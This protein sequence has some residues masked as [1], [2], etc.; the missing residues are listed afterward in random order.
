MNHIVHL[1]S[2]VIHMIV[3][4]DLVLCE[5]LPR[6]LLLYKKVITYQT[7][8][9]KDSSKKLGSFATL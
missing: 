4:H 9:I 8:Y 2:N 1:E 6:L 3:C 5:S 7:K